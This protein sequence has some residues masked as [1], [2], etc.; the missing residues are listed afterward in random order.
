LLAGVFL[1]SYW[2]VLLGLWRTWGYNEDYSGGRIVPLIAVYLVWSDRKA[3]TGTPIR[4]CWWGLVVLVAAQML[5]IAGVLLSYGSLEQYSV[6]FSIFG[7]VLLVL[8]KPVT[9]R[10]KWVLVF[11]LLMIPLPRRVHDEVALPL[12]SLATSSAV[13]GLEMLG[14]LVSREG[15]VLW[16]NDKTSI[17]V[18]EACSGLRMLTAFVVVSATLAFIVRRPA[19][20]KGALVLS[21][22]PVAILANTLRVVATA[23]L[24]DRTNGEVARWFFHDLAGII[25]MPIAVAASIGLL[26]LMRWL[27]NSSPAEAAPG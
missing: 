4:T 26:S 27:G 13:L 8:G 23:L 24:Y 14:V 19:W 2:P 25:M 11:L 15:N 6:V 7:I 16:L 21:S 5:R 22:I 9:V 1:W 10:L 20:Q 12:Q 3:L 17:A 18:A